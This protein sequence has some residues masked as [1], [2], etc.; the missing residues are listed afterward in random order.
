VERCNGKGLRPVDKVAVA[1]GGMP[2]EFDDR[3][4]HEAVDVDG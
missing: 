4:A 1:Q 2:V 3:V